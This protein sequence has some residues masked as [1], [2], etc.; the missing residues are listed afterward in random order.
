MTHA[1]E[2]A[3]RLEETQSLHYYAAH[4]LATTPNRAGAT[5]SDIVSLSSAAA[6]DSQIAAV[7]TPGETASVGE[8]LESP[9]QVGY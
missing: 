6:I 5:V 4:R 2:I 1:I 3:Q 7:S 8:E 9:L